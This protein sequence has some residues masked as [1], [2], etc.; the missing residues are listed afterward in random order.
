MNLGE[1]GIKDGKTIISIL[2]VHPYVVSKQ[3]K[4]LSQTTV[5]KQAI[6][7]LYTDILTIDEQIKTGILPAE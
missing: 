5:K 1:Q 3:L 4:S 2:K 7:H 6:Y